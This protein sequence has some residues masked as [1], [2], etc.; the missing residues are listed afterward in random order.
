V[1][2]ELPEGIAKVVGFWGEPKDDIK[3]AHT[4]GE[5]EHIVDDGIPYMGDKP[6]RIKRTVDEE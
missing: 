6:R 4:V 1:T 3:L 5:V 2:D